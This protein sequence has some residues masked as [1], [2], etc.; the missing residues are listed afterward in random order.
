MG[1]SELLD[2]LTH[3]AERASNKKRLQSKRIVEKNV[4]SNNLKGSGDA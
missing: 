1:L 2:K 4:S 3:A